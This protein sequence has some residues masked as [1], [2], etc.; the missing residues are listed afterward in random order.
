MN[1]F[2][3]ILII[4]VFGISTEKTFASAEKIS[5]IPQKKEELITK[6]TKKYK[7]K[8]KLYSDY[9]MKDIASEIKTELE[10]E[11]NNILADLRILWQAAIE[12]SETIRFAILKLSN[13]NGDEKKES[14]AKR[15]FAPLVNI[16]PLIGA[17]LGD[18]II[19]SSTILGSGFLGSFLADDSAINNHL[20]K[21]TDVDLVMLAQET[22]N[23]QQKLVNLY[24]NYLS[25]L[26]KLN[27]MDKIVQNRYKYYEAA[28]NSS[29]ESIA[30]ADVFYREA[31][32]MQYRARQETLNS[33]A[34]LEQFVGNEALVQIDK[35]IKNRS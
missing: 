3:A 21:V 8:T 27:L 26:K 6:K 34:A 4:I 31:L 32:D 1:K 35:N 25:S 2:L 13:P 17:G 9:D 23:L 24:Y 10:E 15:I 33:R 7:T 16:T 28:Q 22:D 20:S 18:P 19:G 29:A 12:R 30:V 14:I 11:E 5:T